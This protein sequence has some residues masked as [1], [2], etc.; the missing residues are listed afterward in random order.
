M[1][2][3]DVIFGQRPIVCDQ[4]LLGYQT[5]TKQCDRDYELKGSRLASLMR[6]LPVGR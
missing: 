1:A 5:L 2:D 4:G 3:I 6:V